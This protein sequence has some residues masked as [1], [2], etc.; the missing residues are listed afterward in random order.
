MTELENKGHGRAIAM[1]LIAVLCGGVAIL[2]SWNTIAVDMF[3][4]PAME[5]RHAFAVELG[6][7]TAGLLL[8]LPRLFKRLGEG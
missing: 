4:H 5:F 8:C 1:T 2:W 7:I 6:L 3:A